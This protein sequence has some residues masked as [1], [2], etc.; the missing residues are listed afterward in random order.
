MADSGN[1][2]S[3]FFIHKHAGNIENTPVDQ[4]Y[5]YLIIKPVM[6]TFSRLHFWIGIFT[7]IHFAVTGALMRFNFFGIDP[8]DILVRMMLR[9][10][11][12]YI[13][14]AG[15]VNLMAYFAIKDHLSSWVLKLASVVLILSTITLNI[16]FY[17][18][19]I[20]RTLERQFT[21]FSVFGCFGGALLTILYLQFSKRM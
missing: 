2:K 13:V 1:K 12:I 18:D 9:A 5:L 10:N 4:K 17:I 15:L 16:A 19:P 7:L 3:S 14:F 21:A 11:H 8:G 20:G 6:K